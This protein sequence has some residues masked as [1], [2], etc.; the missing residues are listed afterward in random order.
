MKTLTKIVAATLT[1]AI[2][3]LSASAAFLRAEVM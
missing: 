3:T 1:G 2:L